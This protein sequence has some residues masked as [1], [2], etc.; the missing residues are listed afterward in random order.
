MRH[1]RVDVFD[2]R[3]NLNQS[4]PIQ[5]SSGGVFS[6]WDKVGVERSLSCSFHIF[7]H[8]AQKRIDGEMGVHRRYCT[9]GYKNLGVKCVCWY[10]GSTC[11]VNVAC[12]IGVNK[13]IWIFV[14]STNADMYLFC[15]FLVSI[16]F[17]VMYNYVHLCTRS[18]V[19]VSQVTGIDE[20]L[21]YGY[22]YVHIP[23]LFCFS[24]CHLG[25]PN[26][27][28]CSAHNHSAPFGTPFILIHPSVSYLF[29]THPM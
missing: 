25:S 13:Y 24:S 18:T 14:A 11:G 28:P 6:K 5:R 10:R 29:H 19:T 26:P 3:S 22:V 2:R 16:T 8:F 20:T 1:F 17:Y 9:L 4:D 7:M 27:T 15:F 21:L 12:W 23:L